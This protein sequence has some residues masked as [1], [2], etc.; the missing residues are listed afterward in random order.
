MKYLLVLGV[1]M[2]AFWIWRNNRR[3]EAAE[4]AARPAAPPRSAA[5][6]VAMVACR[7]CGTHLP[8]TE[9]VQG[10]DGAYCSAEHRQRLE[11]PAA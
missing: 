10:R 1:V 3:S 7:A 9:A 5:G 6:P 11:G 2:V 4:R 8:H